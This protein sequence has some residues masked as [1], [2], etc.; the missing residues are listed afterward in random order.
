MHAKKR[1]EE[2]GG[3]DT[4]NNG[5]NAVAL[6]AAARCRGLQVSQQHFF[7]QLILC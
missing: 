1:K 4:F 5:V 6:A 7:H 3:R 2:K